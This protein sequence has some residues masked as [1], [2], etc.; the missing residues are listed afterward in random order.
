MRWESILHDGRFA[1]AGH[2]KLGG[3]A[4][5]ELAPQR[6]DISRTP[7]QQLSEARQVTALTESA[8]RLTAH[9]PTG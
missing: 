5:H 8:E 6:R 7:S 3:R 1:D 9:D 4:Q 2:A